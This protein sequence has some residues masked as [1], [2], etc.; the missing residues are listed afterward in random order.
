[1]KT[2]YIAACV[3]AFC[4]INS[5]ATAQTGETPALPADA[6]NSDWNSMTGGQWKMRLSADYSAVAAG[7]ANF[8]GLHGNSG[9][10]SA[11]ANIGA[12]IPWND[13]W[14][15][16]FDLTSHDI[17][18]GTVGGEPI[19]DHINT[20]GFNIGI[21][22]HINDQWTVEG[23][24]GP[25]LYAFDSP[26]SSDVGIGGMV[27]AIYKWTPDLTVTFGVSVNPDRDAP[28][29][30]V[31]GVHWQVCSNLSLSLMYPKSGLDYRVTPRLT[32][33]GGFDG[34][35]TVFRADET[36]GNRIGL[37]QYNN[38]LGTYRDFHG[39]VGAEYQIVKGL[40]ASVEGGY[41]F[42]RELDY[43]LIS[44]TLRFDAAPYV[45]VGLK[46]RF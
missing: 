6:T 38:A 25:R 42:G 19:P 1:M 39:G 2:N 16:P 3:A 40:S 11:T 44:E 15:T 10:Q 37:P 13:T 36:M 4:I 27:R 21:G 46:Y 34:N 28:V 33:F 18:L 17:F 41:S 8:N 32:I 31:A 20:L 22:R 9:A 5:T 26:G 35:F 30:P 24:V 45:Q 29:L 14:F 43:R 23:A 12:Q 7:D